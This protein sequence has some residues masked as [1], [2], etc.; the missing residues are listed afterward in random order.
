MTSTLQA[1]YE[2]PFYQ[3]P[4]R[5]EQAQAAQAIWD[6]HLALYEEVVGASNLEEEDFALDAE[7]VR[8]E[9][10]SGI[11]DKD[12]MSRV[13]AAAESWDLPPELFAMQIE[14]AHV[15]SGPAAFS[16][17]AALF[18][19]ANRW[20]VPVGRLLIR[21][22]GSDRDWQVPWVD[23]LSRGYFLLARLLELAKDVS[24]GRSFFPEDEMRF[25]EVQLDQLRD[26]PPSENVRKLLWKQTVRIRD[27]FA[28][29]LPLARELPRGQAASFRRWWL[30]GL[31]ML[32]A[33]ERQKYDLWSGP[34]LLSRYHRA[35]VRYQARFGRLTF[36]SK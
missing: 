12:A 7:R 21:L 24:A 17:Q 8:V 25:F 6:W 34:V 20:S 13:R 29:A 33:I 32:N 3:D 35:Q 22:A 10:T 26:G 31:E 9:M 16:D 28:Q 11:V 30:A 1:T 5:G 14:A 18:S 4:W 19:F 15:F 27:Q 36:K 23:A 2:L